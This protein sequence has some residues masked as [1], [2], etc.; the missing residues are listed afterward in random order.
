MNFD[1][2]EYHWML[3]YP[4]VIGVSGIIIISCII[5]FKK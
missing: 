4:I 3:G 1:M 2:P 5:L